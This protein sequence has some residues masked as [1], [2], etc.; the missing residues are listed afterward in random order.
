MHTL[1]CEGSEVNNKYTGGYRTIAFA[2]LPVMWLELEP[3][4]TPMLRATRRSSP[5]PHRDLARLC[6]ASVA[7]PTFYAHALP[8]GLPQGTLA[9]SGR[10]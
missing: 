9:V 1:V 8:V 3:F 4:T 5:I 10:S 6:L 2:L 7:W